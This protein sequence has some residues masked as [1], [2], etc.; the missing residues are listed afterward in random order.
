MSHMQSNKL[1]KAA[2][3]A[4]QNQNPKKSRARLTL[5]KRTTKMTT[6]TMMAMYSV[7]GSSAKVW[8][9]WWVELY[10]KLA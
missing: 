5:T 8:L 9:G 1:M 3:N 2:A 7:S 4:I 10:W 6:T